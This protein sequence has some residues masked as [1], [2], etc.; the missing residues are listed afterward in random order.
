M[1]LCPKRFFI[2][3]YA[4]LACFSLF[5]QSANLQ[6]PI[7]SEREFRFREVE[8]RALDL[9]K[10]LSEITG[11]EPIE[12]ID[13]NRSLVPVRYEGSAQRAFDVLPG[14]L[15]EPDPEV[16]LPEL[17]EEEPEPVVFT[18]EVRRVVPTTQQ[19]K[20]D[21]YIMPMIGLAFSSKTKWQDDVDTFTLE[22]DLGNIL[23]V[24]IGRRWDNWLASIMVSY[25]YM[26]FK[27]FAYTDSSTDDLNKLVGN[28]ESYAITLNG[29]Y[30]IPLSEKLSHNGSL[31]LGFAWRRN[32]VN[33]SYLVPANDEDKASWAPYDPVLDSSLVFTY[34]LSLGFEY[35][36]VNN[37]SG[38]FGY[39]LMGLS[40][41][42]S[43]EGAFQHLL[44]L[45]VGANF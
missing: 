35:L 17:K 10:R 41:N 11:T 39:R 37:F 29:G 34:E 38:Y 33:R 12:L 36:F 25:Q 15:Q 19:R 45:G 23:G 43:F 14:P 24:E 27:D 18:S 42:K 31:G 2:A 22:G 8:Q 40:S 6:E 13:R 3:C 28:E 7:I 4:I 26:D 5:G 21:Y 44:E 1:K 30:S 16:E 32:L 9:S 20:G